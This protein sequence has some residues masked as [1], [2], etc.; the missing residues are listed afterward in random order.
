MVYMINRSGSQL[1]KV[2]YSNNIQ[3]RIKELQIANP[4]RLVLIEQW[5]GGRELEKEIHDKLRVDI[6]GKQRKVNRGEW[7]WI[8][9]EWLNVVRFEINTRM[10]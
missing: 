3:R 2:G 4:E 7:F 5:D 9:P 10:L 1:Y 8:S 6:K